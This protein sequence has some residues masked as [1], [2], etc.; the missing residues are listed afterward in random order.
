MVEQ[1]I[2]RGWRRNQRR[3]HCLPILYSKQMDSQSD[4]K[5]K[6]RNRPQMDFEKEKW[7]RR[8]CHAVWQAKIL[9]WMQGKDPQKNS[10]INCLIFEFSRAFVILSFHE[11][12]TEEKEE[13]N[14]CCCNS[15]QMITRQRNFVIWQTLWTTLVR[16]KG[17]PRVHIADQK[18]DS[19][20]GEDTQTLK[21]W[22]LKSPSNSQFPTRRPWDE[23]SDFL[24]TC[25]TFEPL[26]FFVLILAFQAFKKQI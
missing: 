2:S 26:S 1:Q 16:P 3:V 21:R 12:S 6:T 8:L 22:V 24:S 15:W 19:Q 14:Y 11:F 23:V 25:P 13:K 7:K 17:Q 9:P 20:N 18:N 5:P 10:E 4:P